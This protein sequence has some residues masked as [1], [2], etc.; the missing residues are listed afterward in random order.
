M[1]VPLYLFI[2]DDSQTGVQVPTSVHKFDLGVHTKKRETILGKWRDY[3][4]KPD[5]N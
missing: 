3:I 1:M 5:L 2:S 4:L